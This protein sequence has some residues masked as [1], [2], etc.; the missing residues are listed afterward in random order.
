LKQILVNLLN[1]AVKFTPNEGQIGLRV[2]GHPNDDCIR[3]IVWDT[4]VGIAA[5]D[6]DKLFEPFVQI[7]S[8]LARQYQ[9]TG[10]GL[11]LVYRMTKLHS[12]SISVESEVGKGSRFTVS[13]PWSALDQR[14]VATDTLRRSEAT[15]GAAQAFGPVLPLAATNTPW[16]SR[17]N[18]AAHLKVFIADD[19]ETNTNI[20]TD[21]LRA[22]GY[23]VDVAHNG[24][25]ALLR[26]RETKPDLILM[27]I[28]MPGMDGLEVMQQVRKEEGL[29]H[30]PIVALTA[31][32]MPGDRDRCLAA[33]ADEYLSK[34]VSL[35]R[36]MYLIENHC[37]LHTRTI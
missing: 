8:R 14:S 32:A 33:G 27:D 35:Q 28:Q 18:G 13:L 30:V 31:L 37:H 2:Q 20:F 23:E 19:N 29:R 3:F 25:E 4:G 10:L 16:S 22:R 24:T 6:M 1:N 34:P 26:L 12:G 7:D 36:L 15:P 11:A 17:A 21:Y 9:G 5:K